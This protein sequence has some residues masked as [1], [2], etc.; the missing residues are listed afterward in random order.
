[1]DKATITGLKPNTTYT[2]DI[3]SLL[4]DGTRSDYTPRIPAT[5]AP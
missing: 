5:T 4:N 2:I 1:M 3:A